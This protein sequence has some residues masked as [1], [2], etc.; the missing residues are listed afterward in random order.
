LQ[1]CSYLREV[2][3]HRSRGE[4]CLLTPASNTAF[5]YVLWDI[6]IE[7][8]D[9]SQ[10]KLNRLQAHPRERCKKEIV[11]EHGHGDAETWLVE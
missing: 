5:E 11:K 6:N 3:K 2:N 7:N 1:T 9:K 8:F 10:V 4:I